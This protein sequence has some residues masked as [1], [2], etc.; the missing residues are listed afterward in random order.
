MSCCSCMQSAAADVSP[1]NFVAGAS[2]EPDKLRTAG[3]LW[4]S[5][6][7]QRLHIAQHVGKL[8]EV[9]LF[10][11]FGRIRSTRRQSWCSSSQPAAELAPLLG[12]DL[13]LVAVDVDIEPRAVQ[14]LALREPDERRVHVA[15]LATERRVEQVVR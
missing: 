13:D 7:C 4:A 1:R 6:R 5:V 11:G 10:F 15:V 8:R 9:I 14:R 2:D 3:L 12:S